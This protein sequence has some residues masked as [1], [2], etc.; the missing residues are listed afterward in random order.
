MKYK[1]GTLFI[2]LITI[3][4]F[5][6]LANGDKGGNGG[7]AWLCLNQT[8]EKIRKIELIDFFEAVKE[9][10]LTIEENFSLKHGDVSVEDRTTNI[11]KAYQRS[12]HEISKGLAAELDPIFEKIYSK[13][14][15]FI[16]LEVEHEKIPDI[17]NSLRP[18]QTWCK[19]GI[20]DYQVIANFNEE[21]ISVNGNLYLH[22]EFS[23]LEQAGLL[24]HEI[25]YYY[26]RVRYND[27]TSKRA[28]HIVGIIASTL[29]S[30]QK[31]KEL[32]KIMPGLR[33]SFMIIPLRKLK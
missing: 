11:L 32:K 17:D 2:W 10:K 16:D 12:V 13:L 30:N 14:D 20:I 26:T 22:R 6:V 24:L 28:R 25:I 7:G 3:I 23:D 15:F 31:Y 1:F 21:N 9:H 19:N 8:K 33:K 4:S 5:D 27:V 18:S 29:T